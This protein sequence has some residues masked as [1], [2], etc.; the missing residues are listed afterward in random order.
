VMEA[1]RERAGLEEMSQVKFAV[2]ERDGK[3][4]VVPMDQ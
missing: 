2:L 4:T 3:I 1:A